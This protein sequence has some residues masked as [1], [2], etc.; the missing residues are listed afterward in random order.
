MPGMP[1]KGSPGR[2][3]NGVTMK[4]LLCGVLVLTVALSCIL[5]SANA[6]GDPVLSYELRIDGI[7]DKQAETGD[8]VTVS[9]VLRRMDSDEAY[10]M[11]AMQDEIRYDGSCL[12]LVPNSEVTAP[13]VVF[14][15]IAL[16]DGDRK[17]YLNFLSLSGG[18]IWE[19]EKLIGTFRMKVTGTGG[20]SS[21][22]NENTLVSRQD[23]ME[24]YESQAGDAKIIL[25]TQCTIHFMTRGGEEI[26]DLSA[27]YGEAL[28]EIAMPKRAGYRFAGWYRDIDLTKPFN[29]AHDLVDGNMTLYAKWEKAEQPASPVGNML[30]LWIAVHLL[31]A[32]LVAAAWNCDRLIRKRFR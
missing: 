26:P 11:Y 1:P 2:I 10:T 6:Q 28:P 24:S 7:A 12:Q 13:G 9:L 15:D 22:R 27:E 18:E 4:K 14:R 25:S 3:Q 16:V 19:S 29:P 17:V 32:L 23:G 21:V 20:V 31:L 5:I 8:T 30:L